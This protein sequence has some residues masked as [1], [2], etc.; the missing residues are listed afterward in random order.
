M[1]RMHRFLCLLLSSPL[2]E[3]TCS[4]KGIS[5]RVLRKGP[6]P[7]QL[8]RFSSQRCSVQPPF[9]KRSCEYC[10]WFMIRVLPQWTLSG[11]PSVTFQ[12]ETLINRPRQ[13]APSKNHLS[14]LYSPVLDIRH[15]WWVWLQQGAWEIPLRENSLSLY[16]L[17]RFLLWIDEQ[18]EFVKAK[19]EVIVSL[20]QCICHSES[21][22][23][24]LYLVNTRLSRPLNN[25]CGWLGT[26]L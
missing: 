25:V 2:W 7:G 23:T 22:F 16:G 17:L 10:N 24:P 5:R 8:L 6:H 4:L 13:T 14:F 26:H 18:S 1:H 9:K 11:E 15:D 20:S 3:L 21:F 19:G 12:Q